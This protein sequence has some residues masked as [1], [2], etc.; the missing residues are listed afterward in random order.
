M[1]R[2][3]INLSWIADIKH[4]WIYVGLGSM[5]CAPPYFPVGSWWGPLIAILALLSLICYF[6][7]ERPKQTR[8]YC[9]IGLIAG[10][11]I[12]TLIAWPLGK[13]DRENFAFLLSISITLVLLAASADNKG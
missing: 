12:D 5:V 10:A 11:A 3:H 8:L 7:I 1:S 2:P 9:V 4:R 13:V 6:T